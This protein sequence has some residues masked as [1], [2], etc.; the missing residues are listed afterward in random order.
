MVQRKFAT[1]RRFEYLDAMK[2]KKKLRQFVS[3][4]GFLAELN[5]VDLYETDTVICFQHGIHLRPI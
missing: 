4:R 2:S 3:A 5:E 1:S